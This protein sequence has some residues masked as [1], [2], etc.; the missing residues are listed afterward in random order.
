MFLVSG[1]RL[2]ILTRPGVQMAWL[3]LL[4]RNSHLICPDCILCATPMAKQR[5][6]EPNLPHPSAGLTV[7]HARNLDKLDNPQ[8][9][10]VWAA[11]VM[12][13]SNSNFGNSSRICCRVGGFLVA[14]KSILKRYFFL[15]SRCR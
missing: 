6:W 14:Q 13:S 7:Q 4:C 12:L 15:D 3:R 9:R 1:G 11:F 5:I 8:D 10:F 2:Y